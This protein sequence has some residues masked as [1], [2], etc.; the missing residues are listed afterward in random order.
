MKIR[1]TNIWLGSI[2][3]LTL[4]IVSGLVLTAHTAA[5]RIT[6]MVSVA[7][8]LLN[9]LAIPFF[10]VGLKRFKVELQQTY[11]ILCVGIG[12]FGL[13]QVQLPLVN[14]Y[15]WDLWINDGGI[16]IPYL[17]G[18]IL[19]FWSMRRLSQLLAIKTIWRS[20][21]FAL[22]ITIIVSLLAALLPHIKVATDELSYHIAL[23][24]SIWNSVFITFATIV[25]FKVR[26]K[27]GV[28]YAHSVNWLSSALAV[29]SFAGWHY[30]ITQL[31]LTS[32]DWYYDYS[33]PIVPFV[34]GAFL[35]VIAGSAFDAIDTQQDPLNPVATPRD[36]TSMPTSAPIIE[37]LPITPSSSVLS[38]AQEL[39][40]VLYVANLVSNPSDI[41]LIIGDVHRIKSRVARGELPT[42]EDQKVLDHAYNRLEEYLLHQD[43]LRVFTKDELQERIENRFRLDSAVKTTLWQKP[44]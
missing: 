27:I 30:T 18:V 28:T 23:A 34:I 3:A 32:G 24:L 2:G 39:D 16:A 4:A 25:A 12:V 21:S 11:V 15:S 43:A 41:D 33:Y 17:L 26:G 22:L 35:F 10:L 29:L 6:M 42:P 36:I 19:I 40:I 20:A 14:L 7:A 5:F 13:A 8:A 44:Q 1:S 38:P 31:T 37:E 9:L